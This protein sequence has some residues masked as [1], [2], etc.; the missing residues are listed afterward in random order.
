MDE[1]NSKCTCHVSNS[2]PFEKKRRRPCSTLAAS[3]YS[4]RNTRL[5]NQLF[6]FNEHQHSPR[7]KRWTANKDIALPGTLQC[8][9]SHSVHC[10]LSACVCV[11]TVKDQFLLKVDGV[12]WTGTYEPITWLQIVVKVERSPRWLCSAPAF[13]VRRAV[14]DV[15]CLSPLLWNLCLWKCKLLCV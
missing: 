4:S 12:T 7:I 11:C 1:T 5:W 6:D 15:Q 10:F 14:F 2:A 13:I 9:L 3:R 8:D